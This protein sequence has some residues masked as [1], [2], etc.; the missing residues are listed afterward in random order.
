MQNYQQKMAESNLDFSEDYY[1]LR[2]Q[3]IKYIARLGSEQ[4]SD[5]NSHD[6]G[7]TILEQL[8]YAIT[9]L[10]YRMNHSIADILAEGGGDPYVNFIDA[11]DILSSNPVTL[12]DLRKLLID[13]QGVKNAWIEPVTSPEPALY[14]NREKK[15]L[16]LQPKEELVEPVILQ[17]LYQ[18]LVEPDQDFQENLY[19]RVAKKLHEYRN[20]CEDYSQLNILSPQ[21]VQLHVDIKIASVQ[22]SEQLLQQVINAIEG[23]FSASIAFYTLSE[24]VQKGLQMDQIFDGVL[25]ENGFIDND[26]L[27]RL[28]RRTE[29]RISDLIQVIMAIEGVRT[30]Q[31]IRFIDPN[32]IQ[33]VQS[34]WLLPIDE[35]SFAQLDLHNSHFTLLKEQLE[36]TI[37]KQAFIDRYRQLQKV[38][39]IAKSTL[40]NRPEKPSASNRNIERYLS[41]MHQFPDTY[42]VNAQG[43]SRSESVQRKALAKQLKGYLVLFDQVLANSFSQLAHVKDLFSF[44]AQNSTSYF[45]QLLDDVDLGLDDEQAPENRLWSQPKEQRRAVLA[46]IGGP[47]S[48]HLGTPILTSIDTNTRRNQFLDHLLARF[49]ES[50]NDYSLAMTSLRARETQQAIQEPFSGLNFSDTLVKSKQNFL[51]NYAYISKARGSA[52]NY[53]EAPSATN[54]SGLEQRIRLK[55]DITSPDENFYLVE[56]IL[57]RPIKADIAQEMPLIEEAQRSDSYSL[58]LSFMLPNWSVRFANADFKQHVEQV[59]YAQTPAHLY[60]YIKWLSIDEM[61]RF[62]EIH[63]NGLWLSDKQELWGVNQ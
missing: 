32:N 2:Q 58:Q 38:R 21:K 57:L 9:D 62:I 61:R 35:E 26:E 34:D 44:N 24:C 60:V 17:G 15:Q 33:T 41:I 51:K 28:P 36:I 7:I 45:Q 23:Y 30:V 47:H 10:G 3:A 39:K 48:D 53:L 31:N 59:I 12:M 22:D 55:L 1:A 11:P 40:H 49:A 20:L 52:F 19:A 27:Q 4:W 42:A 25:L 46:E 6:P 5:Y 43:I 18:V 50:F 13:I 14:F 37:P 63:N 29:I 8:C 54:R 16:K 56:H